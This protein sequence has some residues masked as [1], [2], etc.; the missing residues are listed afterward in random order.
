MGAW[1]L[2]IALWYYTLSARLQSV[3]HVFPT[4]RAIGFY[5]LCRS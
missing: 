2:I 1:V 5:C 4:S 3:F